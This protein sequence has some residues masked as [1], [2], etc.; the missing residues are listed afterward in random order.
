M[1]LYQFIAENHEEIVRRCTAKVATRSQPSETPSEHGVPLFLDQVVEALRPGV[2]SNPEIG[3]SAV[4][5]GLEL[6]QK[7]FTV[8]Q[9]VH[10]YGDVCQSITGL[11][12]EKEEPISAADFCTLNRCLDEAIAGAVTEY[13]RLRDQPPVDDTAAHEAEHLG[14]LTHELRNLVNTAILSFEVLETGNV[15]VRGST[16]RVLQRSL[17]GMRTL[18]GRSVAELRLTHGVR[19]RDQILLAGFI[20]EVSAAGI[21]EA[22]AKGIALVVE[23]TE[24]EI[25]VE[26]DRAVL[27]AALQNLLQNAFK[28]TR[29]HT[30]VIVRVRATADRVQI[31][32]QDECGGLPDRTPESLFTPFDRRS[33]SRTGLG[34]GLAFSRRG[35]EADGGR[36]HARSLPG[37]GCI[38]TLDLPRLANRAVVA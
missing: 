10:D 15:G 21:L 26:G 12:V 25:A 13:G 32:V 4:R 3:R 34:L 16:G 14:F 27:A 18:V 2:S 36:L 19:S 6:L 11:A 30:V 5:H 20:E 23:P 35:V 9:V 29:P 38:F 22:D 24:G 8:S 37:Q 28:F 17:R 1:A 7:G 33:A 31:E